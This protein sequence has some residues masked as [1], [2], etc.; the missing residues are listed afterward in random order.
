MPHSNAEARTYNIIASLNSPGKA[1][2]L[3]S[4]LSPSITVPQCHCEP[5]QK[6]S[7]KAWLECPELWQSQ[8]GFEW[9]SWKE[10]QQSDYKLWALG[11]CSCR[12][13]AQSTEHWQNWPRAYTM[14]IFSFPLQLAISLWSRFRGLC[15]QQEGRK[16]K[17]PQLLQHSIT[18]GEQQGSGNGNS[19]GKAPRREQPLPA[20]PHLCHSLCWS[21]LL[22][23][24]PLKCMGVKYSQFD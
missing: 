24:R 5:S 21:N 10:I 8:G 4:I 11:L 20:S 9:M 12:G 15:C 19:L 1:S 17:T 6:D 7:G 2:P 22:L 14:F 16:I 23:L 13:W 18:W 3:F